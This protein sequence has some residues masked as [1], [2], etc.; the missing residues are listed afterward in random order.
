M[1]QYTKVN[2]LVAPVNLKKLLESSQESHDLVESTFNNV[3]DHRLLLSVVKIF[4]NP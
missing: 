4:T 1:D 3:L 2:L